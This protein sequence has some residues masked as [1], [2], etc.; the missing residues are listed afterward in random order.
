MNQD[1]FFMKRC[2]FLAKKGG[3]EALPN[4]HVGAVI[5]H[6]GRIIGEGWHQKYGGPH[7]EVMAF[8]SVKEKHLLPESTLY[9]SLEP[10]FHQGK[11]PPC[12]D[13]TLKEGVKRVVI[14]IPDSY[15][16][17][18]GKSIAKLKGKGIDV[19]VGVLEDEGRF[20][21]RRFSVFHREKRPYIILKCARSRDGFMGHPDK[22]VWLTGEVAKRWSHKWRTEEAAIIVGRETAR[23]DNPK[24][25]PRLFPGKSPLRMVVDRFGKLPKNLHLFDGKAKTVVVSETEK[26]YPNAETWI[27][28]S[29][30]DWL[31]FTMD[32]LYQNG[33]ASLIVEGGPTLLQVFMDAGLW[34]EARILTSPHNLGNGVRP[35]TYPISDMHESF[36][37]GEDICDIYYRF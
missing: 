30:Q 19:R 1:E 22:Q 9:V 16:E 25:T 26:A 31:P 34:D 5:V 24:L 20:L 33:I 4:P 15:H 23:M 37:M 11:T 8:E 17:V 27:Y 36:E 14:S 29:G 6:D 12:V 32:K 3:G 7:A 35:R 18:A 10:C 21:I 28:P 2:F 13:R